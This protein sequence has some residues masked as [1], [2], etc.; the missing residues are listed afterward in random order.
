MDHLEL[1]ASLK[2]SFLGGLIEISGSANYLNTQREYKNSYRFTRQYHGEGKDVSIDT[3][4]SV[5]N[6]HNCKRPG[7]THVVT[8]VKYGFNAFMTFEVEKIEDEKDHKIGKVQ[9]NVSNPQ[10]KIYES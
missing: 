3:E 9:I 4:M 8:A 2:V 6:H 10:R 7:A 1:D 5:V